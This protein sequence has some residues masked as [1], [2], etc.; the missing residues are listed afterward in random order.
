MSQE[1]KALRA[2]IEALKSLL[3]MKQ[4]RIDHLEK[5]LASAIDRNIGVDER[6][7]K[8]YA[9]SEKYSWRQLYKF[10][11]IPVHAFWSPSDE[12]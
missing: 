8:I 12:R 3:A 11:S 10:T 7:P 9:P 2:E 6:S 4:M 1:V 5:A